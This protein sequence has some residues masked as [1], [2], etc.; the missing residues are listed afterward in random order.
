VYIVEDSKDHPV[1][2]NELL[3]D[4]A[5]QSEIN[6]A[7]AYLKSCI[8]ITGNMDVDAEKK[9]FIKYVCK[10]PYIEFNYIEEVK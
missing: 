6:A 5:I 3:F 10:N 8:Q 7:N 1:N 4:Y 9:E 2:Q